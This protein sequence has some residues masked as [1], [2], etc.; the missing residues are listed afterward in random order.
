MASEIELIYCAN[1]NARY[2]EIAIT[3]GFT[4]GAQLPGTVYFRPEFVDQDWRNPDFDIYMSQLKKYKP[5][6]ATVIDWEHEVQL[7]DVLV[8]AESAAV[9]VDHV[10]IIPKVPGR[11]HLLP[12]IIG[13]KPVRLGFSVP[14][15]HG[16]TSCW[17]SEFLGWPVHLLGGS[18]HAQKN[19]AQYMNVV[20]VDGNMHNKMANQFCAFYDPAKTT[21]CGYWPKIQDYDGRKWPGD[22]ANYEAFR[23]SCENIK[24]F[25]N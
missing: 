8:W 6:M 16:G 10:L 13:G 25:W 15:K 4:Y 11:V 2:A 19:Y 17:P 1:G 20:S 9:F 23:R 12:K 21:R 5:R 7:P 24:K 22:G 18:P 3:A 14:T